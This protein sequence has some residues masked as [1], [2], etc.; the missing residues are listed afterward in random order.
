MKM[1][2]SI[3]LFV[4]LVVVMAA[5][6]GIDNATD[7]QLIPAV[8]VALSGLLLMASGVSAMNRK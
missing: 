4:G 3:R 6:G 5:G 1:R 8:M 2:G 7:A